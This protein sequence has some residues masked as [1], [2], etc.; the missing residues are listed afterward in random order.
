M[1]EYTVVERIVAERSVW[2]EVETAP[3]KEEEE[4][5][6]DDDDEEMRE[7]ENGSESKK[8]KRRRGGGAGAGS[9]MREVEH[10]ELLVKWRGLPYSECTWEA[11]E[12]VLM[13]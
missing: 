10:L 11:V 1:E 13:R 7:N 5:E 3:E 9:A 2:V 6:N 12:T 8:S 4:E